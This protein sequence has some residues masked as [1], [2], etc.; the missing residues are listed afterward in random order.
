[1]KNVMAKAQGLKCLR[2]AT[3]LAGREILPL[4]TT[5]PATECATAL[6]GQ[7][8]RH[9][10][11]RR[12][13]LGAHEEASD[14]RD[15]GLYFGEGSRNFMRLDLHSQLPRNLGGRKY[16]EQGLRAIFPVAH[17]DGMRPAIRFQ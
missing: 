10:R 11:Y 5:P 7:R 4:W 3:S 12:L 8:L 13:P 6:I 1:M 14:P 15:D 2:S 16:P 17:H 9:R